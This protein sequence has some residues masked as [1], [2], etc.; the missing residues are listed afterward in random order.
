MARLTT[1]EWTKMYK[2]VR[3]IQFR[4]CARC[5]LCC[6]FGDEWYPPRL[7][8]G[9]KQYRRE[10]GLAVE[11][12][13]PRLS[14]PKAAC[15]DAPLICRVFPFMVR[16]KGAELRVYRVIGGEDTYAAKCPVKDPSLKCLI[17]GLLP[18]LAALLRFDPFTPGPRNRVR[19]LGVY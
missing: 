14:D 7:L 11:P 8:W 13:C 19:L 17:P 2:A 16:R 18:T 4:D 3:R 10:M 15:R 1:E 5:Q 6:E 9:E 12:H